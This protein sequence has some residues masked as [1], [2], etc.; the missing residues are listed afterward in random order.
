MV[1]A[2]GTLTPPVHII[3]T[4]LDT[5]VLTTAQEGVYT[6]RQVE[7]LSSDRIKRFFL[8]GTGS[9]EGK[10]RVRKELCDMITFQQLNLLEESW[11]LRGSLDAIFCR[12]VMIYFDKPTQ[13]QILQ[14]FAPLLAHDG[15]LFAGHSENF[16]HA[17]DLFKLRGKTIYELT[18]RPQALHG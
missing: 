18:Y 13:Y 11:P 12:N 8:K 14:K 2:F 6:A 16:Y 9:Q 5:K 7:K 1:E 17:T 3:A 10:F 15:L 4:D